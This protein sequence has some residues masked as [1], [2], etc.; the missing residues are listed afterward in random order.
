VLALDQIVRADVVDLA[1]VRIVQRRNGVSFALETLTKADVAL[2]DGDDTIQARV[3]HSLHFA[4]AAR[5]E[6]VQGFRT[7]RVSRL[8]QGT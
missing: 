7:A 8:R 2:L 6:G 4:H 1:N 3:A 5:A